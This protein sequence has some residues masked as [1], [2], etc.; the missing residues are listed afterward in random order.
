MS[1]NLAGLVVPLVIL[2]GLVLI[3]ACS[4]V[5]WDRYRP[6]RDRPNPRAHPTGE[7]FIDPETGTRMRVWFDPNTGV[8]EYRRD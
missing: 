4:I 2:G 6:R 8:R 1:V 7:V 5:G 3:V